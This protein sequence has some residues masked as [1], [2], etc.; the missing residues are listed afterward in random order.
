VRRRRLPREASPR[1]CATAHATGL[2]SCGACRSGGRSLAACRLPREA[3]PRACAKHMPR[4]FPRAG[5]VGRAE[6]HLP[7]C[8]LPREASPRA[9]RACDLPEATHT[10]MA[11]PVAPC[12]L[13][14]CRLPGEA[15]PRAC[16]K[17][18]AAGLCRARRVGRTAAAGHLQGWA[19]GPACPSPAAVYSDLK[20]NN[21][22]DDVAVARVS[23]GRGRAGSACASR[24]A[25]IKHLARKAACI[26]LC[27]GK[28]LWF[29][30]S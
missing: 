1:A 24:P 10:P 6:G 4:A 7:A 18:Q 13:P 30:L 26:S 28:R 14:A 15:S 17:A 27:A 12:F 11:W 23:V 21:S 25:C 20:K 5:R 8:R 16:A 9:V 2:S 19:L 29:C 22:F 3:S